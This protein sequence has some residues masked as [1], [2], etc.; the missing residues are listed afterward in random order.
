MTRRSIVPLLALA[1]FA[2][3]ETAQ[4][5]VFMQER[6]HRR[7]QSNWLID[8]GPQFARPVGEFRTN[9]ERAWGFGA[10]ARYGFER[11]A[12]LGL[13]IDGAF[14]NYGNERKEVPLSATVNRVVVDMNT[15]N[16]IALVTA[17]PELAVRRGLIRPYVYGFA[18]FSYLFTE[19]TVGDD[20]DGDGGFASTTNFDDGGW[21]TGWGGGL[22]IPFN[23][24]RADV[25]LDLGARM[26]RNGTRSYL[27]RGDIVDQPDGSLQF[28]ERRTAVEFIQYQIGVSIAP[29]HRR[30]RRRR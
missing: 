4:S 1:T 25:A 10:S 16:N 30:D 23:L 19:S 2:V 3:A 8:L 20:G 17:G 27:R 11:L 24:R 21:A 6:E 5:Q 29:G 18:G 22:R 15:A 28:T 12:P 7:R 9:V 14:F 13:R 26:T